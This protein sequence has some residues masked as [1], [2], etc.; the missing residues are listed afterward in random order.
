MKDRFEG[1]DLRVTSDLRAVWRNILD[2]HLQ[3]S[4]A[5]LDTTELP[6]TAGLPRLDL[7]RA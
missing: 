5:A 7:L 1:R 3:V 4:R 2:Q 6:G